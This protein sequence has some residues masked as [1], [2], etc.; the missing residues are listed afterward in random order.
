MMQQLRAKDGK[1]SVIACVICAPFGVPTS[2]STSGESLTLT[3]PPPADDK[4]NSLA[5]LKSR[6]AAQI[7]LTGDDEF[8]RIARL[9]A[10]RHGLHLNEYGLWRWRESPPS[11][12]DADDAGGYWELV[13]GE[14]ELR[15]LDEIGLGNVPPSRRNFRFLVRRKRESARN[16]T[17]DLGLAD[18]ELFFTKRGRPPRSPGPAAPDADNPSSEEGGVAVGELLED[19]GDFFDVDDLI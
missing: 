17:L 9:A 16:G 6:G 4:C 3:T 11:D 1:T 12:E 15:I 13:E 8:L 19:V 14:N 5:P 2:V 7:A 18:A 10:V